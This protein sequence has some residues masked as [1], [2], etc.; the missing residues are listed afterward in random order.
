MN[1]AERLF[2]KR[3]K[4][5]ID[6]ATGNAIKNQWVIKLLAGVAIV[7][8][9]AGLSLAYDLNVQAHVLSEAELQ[10]LPLDLQEVLQARHSAEPVR[11]MDV[12]I[13]RGVLI[14]NKTR[15]KT[16]VADWLATHSNK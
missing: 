6:Q 14:E 13:V 12:E 10:Q 3:L 16:Q 1:Y 4:V 11:Q 2:D 15:L 7:G 5:Q 8:A 9:L